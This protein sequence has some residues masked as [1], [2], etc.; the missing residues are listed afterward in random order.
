VKI[1]H[2]HERE[3][4]RCEEAHVTFL[5]AGAARASRAS[6]ARW[7]RLHRAFVEPAHAIVFV[8]GATRASLLHHLHDG[9]DY[10]GPSSRCVKLSTL[11]PRCQ[12][13]SCGSCCVVVTRLS[14]AATRLS[15]A[16]ECANIPPCVCSAEVKRA[17][18]PC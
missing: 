8:A 16:R 11:L 1:A 17:S 12:R 18:K 4:W 7:A 3:E 10:T 15:R 6:L 2:H 9:P 13:R 5:V 14:V